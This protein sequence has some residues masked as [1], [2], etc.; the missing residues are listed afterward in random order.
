MRCVSTLIAADWVAKKDCAL[1]PAWQL[2]QIK[3][4]DVAGVAAPLGR[5]VCAMVRGLL[6]RDQPCS[7]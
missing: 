3:H 2:I 6:Y 5:Q 7:E 1:R 4:A